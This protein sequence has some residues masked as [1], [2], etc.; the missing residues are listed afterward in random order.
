M[1]LPTQNISAFSQQAAADGAALLA[2]HAVQAEYT[3]AAGVV[4]GEVDLVVSAEPNMQAGGSRFARSAGG[5]AASGVG[6]THE[7]R[8]VF[9][10]VAGL[11]PDDA[12]SGSPLVGRK[13]VALCIGDTF[14]VPGKS[15]GRPHAEAGV[16]LRVAAK[17]RF[18]EGVW[19]AEAAL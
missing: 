15:V 18:V 12:V 4:A 19:T 10:Q 13:V 16:L 8:I 5:S 9:V 6:N 11:S 2:E 3:T 17:P 14:L 1:P 7:R